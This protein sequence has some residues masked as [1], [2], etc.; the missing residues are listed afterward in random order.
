I[1]NILAGFNNEQEVETVRKDGSMQISFLR[2]TAIYLPGGHK[3]VLSVSHDITAHKQAEEK[4]EESEIKY[5]ELVENSPDGIVIYEDGIVVFANQECIRMMAA[6]NFN[7]LIGKSVIQ[8]VHPDY[9]ELVGERM[10]KVLTDGIPLPLTH[11]KF[12]RLDGTEVDVEVMAMP[13]RL[14]NKLAVQLIIRDITDR[15]KTEEDLHHSVLRARR[16]R[17]AI[18]S[19]AVEEAIFEGDISVALERLT[20][21]LADAIMVDRMSVWSFKNNDTELECV[22][23]FESNKN[24]HNKGT[25]LKIADFPNYFNALIS[26]SLVSASD[27][28][29]DFRTKEFTDNYLK[30]LGITSMLDAGIWIG[31]KAVGVVCFEHI[32]SI[33]N[34][35]PDEEAFANTAAAI[36]M[37]IY[38]NA[39]RRQAE[40]ALKENEEKYRNIFNTVQDVFFQTNLEGTITE[41]SPSVNIFA[42]YEREE[43]LGTDVSSVYYNLEDR[44]ILLKELME[45]GELQDFETLFKTKSGAPRHV[46]MNVRLIRDEEGK[47]HHLNG[48]IRDITERKNTVA[49]LL[50][51][52]AKYRMMF[53]NNPQPMMIYDMKTLAFLEVNDAAI[54]HYGYSKTKFLSMTILDIHLKEDFDAVMKDIHSNR[55]DYN[56]ATIWRHVKKNGE[57]IYVEISTHSIHHNNR[58]ARHIMVK[59]ITKRK[60]LEEELNNYATYQHNIREEERIALAREIHDELGQTLIAIK[61]DLTML[62]KGILKSQHHDNSTDL[63]D[64]IDHVFELIDGAIK[65]TRKVMTELRFEVLDML[66]FIEAINQHTY[67]FQRRYGINCIVESTTPQLEL[68]PKQSVE[69]FRIIQEALINVVK[70]AKATEV[71]ILLKTHADKFTLEITDNGIGLT[72]ATLINP[73]SYGLIGIRERTKLLDG[74]LSIKGQPG[75]GTIIKV[76]IAYQK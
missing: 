62:K 39:D 38:S 32:G 29:N 11:E 57:I 44:D 42:E 21:V 35:H 47:P 8:F 10:K 72:K 25:I 59:D 66:G 63:L 54:H 31:G 40:E 45:K 41:I 61:F 33:R 75:K 51:S 46:S 55:R 7:E 28:Q 15:K 14:K 23:L 53:A 4:L 27:A 60:L 6:T 2:E 12:I 30:P 34:W 76:E 1:K 58:K 3:G 17:E 67:E 19:L 56:S 74:K 69:L 18:A 37:Q 65:N 36:V 71:T 73:H 48:A 5:R 70:H 50:E 26:E 16:Q 20:Q 49:A 52:E 64:K 22:C 9:R 43:L 24:T 13:I 68:S